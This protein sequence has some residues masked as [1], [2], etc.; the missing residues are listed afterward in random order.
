MATLPPTAA[1]KRGSDRRVYP[2]LLG[3]KP[4]A[5]LRAASLLKRAALGVAS[6]W[7]NRDANALLLDAA[8]EC[9]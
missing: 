7:T 5:A 4:C 6:E 8:A 3:N 1:R 9:R 2:I